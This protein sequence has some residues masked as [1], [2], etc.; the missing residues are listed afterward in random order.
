[1]RG[2]ADMW[3]V[4]ADVRGLRP[5]HGGPGW[6]EEVGEDLRGLNFELGP[7]GSA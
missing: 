6:S 1:M 2:Q 4:L 7:P 5:V 3:D